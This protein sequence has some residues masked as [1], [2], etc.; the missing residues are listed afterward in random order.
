MVVRLVCC[1]L[2]VVAC[3][4][5]RNLSDD[6]FKPMVPGFYD[7]GDDFRNVSLLI[8]KVHAEELKIAYGFVNDSRTTRSLDHCHDHQQTPEIKEKLVQVMTEITNMWLEPLRHQDYGGDKVVK[9]FVFTY[10]PA[11]RDRRSGNWVLNSKRGASFDLEVVFSCGE[12]SFLTPT[13]SRG[14]RTY[15]E[16]TP[17]FIIGAKNYR[18]DER[19]APYVHERSY[20]KPKMIIAF[21]LAFGLKDTPPDVV[22]VTNNNTIK[23]LDKDGKLV[24]SDDDRKG[25]R[26]LYKYHHD[27]VDSCLF[28]DYQLVI[29]NK[30][31]G[32][33]GHTMKCI[34]KKPMIVMVKQAHLQESYENFTAAQQIIRE[35]RY[36]AISSYSTKNWL[37]NSDELGNTLLHYVGQYWQWSTQQ[38][39]AYNNNLAETKELALSLADLWKE[40]AQELIKDCQIQQRGNC[41]L[42]QKTNKENRTPC[43]YSMIAKLAPEDC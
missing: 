5:P 11:I 6:K 31:Y 1:L 33:Q 4:A 30:S 28:D 9:K 36:K 18:N 32:A 43:H 27:S 23:L 7:Q 38:S 15:Y 17:S 22:S 12:H 21:A 3:K 26:W 19:F 39:Q 14:R 37:D 2:V 41:K 40:L 20:S 24:L 34:P 35:V 8:K 10:I 13:S 29:T 16:L 42:L 25:I